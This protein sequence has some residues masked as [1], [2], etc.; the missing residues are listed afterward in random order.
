MSTAYRP[1]KTRR[2]VFLS[3]LGKS[4]KDLQEQWEPVGRG[5]SKFWDLKK[6]CVC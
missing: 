3:N 1:G 6:G 4:H 2:I 5:Y